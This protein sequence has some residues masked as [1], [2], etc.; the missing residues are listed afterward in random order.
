MERK[1]AHREE[2]AAMPRYPVYYHYIDPTYRDWIVLRAGK[3]PERLR[4]SQ[5]PEIP[6][7]VVLA[8]DLPEGKHYRIHPPKDSSPAWYIEGHGHRI[9]WR[10]EPERGWS[11][12]R[13][14]MHM[15]IGA[16]VGALLV[17]TLFGVPLPA[18]LAVQALV[19]V[20]FLAYEITEG[21]RILDMA[22]RDI[23]GYLT[24]FLV[25]SI[26]ALASLAALPL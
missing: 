14:G 17:L 20:L 5:H 13:E 18:V 6:I 16:V 21:I 7:G 24:G 25:A 8:N 15:G 2:D 9:R 4:Y 10:K 11:I 22:Y 19:T 12:T 3:D 26:A 23:G 1:L